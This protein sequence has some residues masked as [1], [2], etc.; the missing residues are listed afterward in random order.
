MSNIETLTECELSKLEQ[1]IL[2][3]RSK[4][5]RKNM[6]SVLKELM[7]QY[8]NIEET[9]ECERKIEFVLTSE[10]T[11]NGSYHDLLYYID[12]VETDEY[13]VSNL[14]SAIGHDCFIDQSEEELCE[15]EEAIQQIYTD[16]AKIAK[17]INED[18]DEIWEELVESAG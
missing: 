6:R 2:E 15:K 14:L 7:P 12:G 16:I 9:I 11:F 4:R 17:K 1:N 18:T 8:D 5:S 13:D 3:E 10:I